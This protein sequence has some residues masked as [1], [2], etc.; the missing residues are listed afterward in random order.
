MQP[1]TRLRTAANT[2]GLLLYGPL[3]LGLSIWG[4]MWSGNQ[5]KSALVL[6]VLIASS[7]FLIV[8]CVMVVLTGWLWYEIL[9]DRKRM[10]QAQT[11]QTSDKLAMTG[12]AGT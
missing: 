3:I 11:D 7:V 12:E 10:K 4:L 5:D 9:A 1:T 6:L 2:V 8:G